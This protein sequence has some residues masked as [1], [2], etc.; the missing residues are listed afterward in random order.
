MS[1]ELLYLSNADVQDVQI[2]PRE[3]RE[4]VICAFRDNA[5]GSNIGLPKSTITIGPNSWFSSMSAASET[6]SLA[7]M[8]WV[9]AIPVEG[10]P[11]R[12][13]VNGL[14]CMSD[15]KTGVPIAVLDGNSITLIRTAAMSAA[16]ASFLGPQAPASIGLIGCGLQA[17]SHIDAFADLF[18]SLRR[19]HLLSRSVLSAER[20]AAAAS[21]KK[22]DP[23]ITN[24]PDALLSESEI[25]ITMVPSSPGL[26]S[27]LD[28][29]LL[30]ASSFV[31][32][33]DGGRS[34]RSETLSAF[35][36]FVTD[37]LEQSSSP[38]DASDRYVESIRFQDDLVH[39]AYSSPQR[40]ASIRA[41]FGFRG[42][43]VAD[44]ALAGL[45]LRKARAC[46]IGRILPR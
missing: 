2:S 42:F 37:A 32:A 22:L 33:V 26:K 28:A 20:A 39:L 15:Y 19:I 38:V 46:R 7:T 30:P 10:M 23:I 3:A 17:L 41:F 11:E 4:A 36:V 24:N 40:V 44:L 6:K 21:K 14:I 18:P 16:A 8:K 9:A 5:A 43:A 45:A 12:S 29:R 13:T 35:D 1:A 34:W 25:V 31:S 27:F